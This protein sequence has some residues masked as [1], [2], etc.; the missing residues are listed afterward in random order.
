MDEV[1]VEIGRLQ[2]VK[3]PDSDFYSWDAFEAW[4]KSEGIDTESIDFVPTAWWKC[5][6]TAHQAGAQIKSCAW[7][8]TTAAER[9]K[10]SNSVFS[11][12]MM[13]KGY[14]PGK[15]GV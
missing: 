9:I 13:G 3:P 8:P 12:A 2:M 10:A 4:C 15:G 11:A 14:S 7:G 5:W 1:I 6:R